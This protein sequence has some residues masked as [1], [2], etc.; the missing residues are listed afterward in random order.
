MFFAIPVDGL[1]QHGMNGPP[2]AKLVAA[3]VAPT[4]VSAVVTPRR[5]TANLFIA[6]SPSIR[7]VPKVCTADR[8]YVSLCEI[9]TVS[10][11]DSR[12]RE[13]GA[14]NQR[15][16]GQYTNM[17]GPMRLERGTVPQMRESHELARSSPMK[18]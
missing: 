12:F 18:K 17:T 8:T 16:G 14:Q 9:S 15:S 3:N 1:K 2:P 7:V 10:A 4:T 13:V 5:R 11:K 6:R